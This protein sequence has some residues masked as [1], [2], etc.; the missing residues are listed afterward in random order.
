MATVKGFRAWLNTIPGRDPALH[1]VG[2]VE[3][4]TGGW[5][6]RLTAA[7][8]QGSNPAVLI[9]DAGLV[10][11]TAPVIEVVSRLELRFQKTPGPRYDSVTIR[12]LGDDFDVPVEVVS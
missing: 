1:V 9:L 4:P 12:G 11:P 7:V 6:G 5:Q 3:V 10:A 2:I 8:P